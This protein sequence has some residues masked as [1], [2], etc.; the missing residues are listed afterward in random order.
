MD[1]VP[2]YYSDT[3]DYGTATVE[4]LWDW[5]DVERSEKFPQIVRDSGSIHSNYSL[6]SSLTMIPRNKV[7]KSN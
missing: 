6:Y 4:G 5:W 1:P 2:E 7:R 3:Y